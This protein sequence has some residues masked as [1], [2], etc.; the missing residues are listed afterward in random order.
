MIKKDVEGIILILSCEK[1]SNTR[2]KEFGPK[3]NIYNNFQVIKVIGNI[4]LHTDYILNKNIL[5]VKCEDSY[6]HL[7]KKLALSIKYLNLEFN[8]RQGILRC[9]DDLIFNE[10]NLINFLN[11]IKFDYYGQAYCKKNYVSEDISVLKNTCYDPFMLSYY[12]NHQ[13]ELICEKH[14]INKSLNELNNFLVRPRLYGACGII[15]YLSNKA[16]QIIVD[17]ME[18]IDY[19]IF[20]LDEYSNSYP[21]IIEDV[22]TSYIMYYNKINFIHSDV[23]FDNPNSICRHTNKYK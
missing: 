11:G 7:M 8:I 22:A 23:F 13:N 4:Y 17:T 5:Y 20:H 9:G 15:Y 14:G 16:C 1:H 3:Q 10:D 12:K 2:L 18:K 19:N 21:Y 6:L